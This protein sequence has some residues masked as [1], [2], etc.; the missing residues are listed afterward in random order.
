MTEKDC[1][2]RCHK[3]NNMC[4]NCLAVDGENNSK[5]ELFIH[6]GYLALHLIQII[7]IVRM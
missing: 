3:A 5:K 4:T 7:L 6:L 2:T 1:C